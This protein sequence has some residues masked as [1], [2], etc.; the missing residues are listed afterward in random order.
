MKKSINIIKGIQAIALLYFIICTILGASALD[1][2]EVITGQAISVWLT[3]LVTT[4]VVLVAFEWVGNELIRSLRRKE[5]EERRERRKE[6]A[7]MGREVRIY[8]GNYEVK[9]T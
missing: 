9:E 4:T 5:H 2:M 7:K 1:S 6:L 8:K 3:N